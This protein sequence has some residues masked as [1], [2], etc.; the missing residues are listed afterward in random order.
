MKKVSKFLDIKRVKRNFIFFNNI[1]TLEGDSPV[2]TFFFV[3]VGQG[4]YT[5]SEYWGTTLKA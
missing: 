4:K 2:I 5:L 3:L 1:S